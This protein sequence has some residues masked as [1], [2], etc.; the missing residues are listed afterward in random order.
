MLELKRLGVVLKPKDGPNGRFAKFNAGMVAEDDTV[1]MLYRWSEKKEP[2]TDGGKIYHD[3][4]YLRNHISYARLSLE[5]KLAFD[6]DRPAIYPTTPLET[7][8]CEDARI[9]QFEG[10]YYI[11]YCAYD[12]RKARV[13]VASTLD[14]EHYCKLGI[15]DIFTWDK[16]AFIFPERIDGKIAFVHRIDPSI[17]IDYFES[18]GHLLN[19]E[20]WDNYE[21]KVESSTVL[22]AVFDWEGLKIG[23]GVPP[24]KTDAG[25]LLIYHGVDSQRQY[26]AGVALLDLR[27]PSVVRARLPYPILSPK[28]DYEVHG[29]YRGC[30]FP[31]GAY[32][33]DGELYVSY[34]A[35]DENVAIAKVSLNEL[36]DELCRHRVNE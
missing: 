21:E 24:I 1:H 7:G 17:Q 26:H 12:G 16:D 27:N 6:S 36:V 10:A 30:V 3:S 15:I 2:R 23:G 19:P 25:W 34:G 8:G 33:H 32:V 20:S 28:A 4:P 31:Q 22:R 13:A 9:V 35:A 14:F 5:G 29:H 18:F 11:F